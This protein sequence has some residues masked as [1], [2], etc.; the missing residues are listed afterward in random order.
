[1]SCHGVVI[2]FRANRAD[3]LRSIDASFVP[4]SQVSPSTA[5][6]TVYS[7]QADAGRYE[8]YTC[9]RGRRRLI[10]T[11]DLDRLVSFLKTHVERTVAAKAADRIFFHA[12]AVAWQGK[13]ILLPGRSGSG[14]SSL[15]RE[16]IRAGAMYLSDEFAVVDE[17]G[18]VYPF[19][20]PLSLR[21]AAGKLACPASDFAAETADGPLPV[22]LL[23]F[24]E[25]L[26][27]SAFR[28]SR[29][30][31]GRAALE[32]LK[33]TVAVRAQPRRAMRIAMSVVSRCPAFSSPRGH[34]DLAAAL[35]LQLSEHEISASPIHVR[36][37]QC[38][39]LPELQI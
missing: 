37:I 16:L 30:T 17:E 33:H 10:Q 18:L 36:P 29:L 28:A 20:R 13:A 2:G 26:P 12:G 31:A 23:V 4:G 6:R 15:V 38:I 14:K 32:L 3:L 5:P 8:V 7:L 25:Y 1:V 34:A 35:V 24:T 22:G 19:A 11:R 21:T 27:E 9:F 39:H